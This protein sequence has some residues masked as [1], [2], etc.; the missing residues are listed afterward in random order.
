[1]DEAQ[2]PA[3]WVAAGHGMPEVCSRHGAPASIRKRITI[4]S[5]AARRSNL[6]WFVSPV[7]FLTAARAGRKRVRARLWP[8]C[9]ACQGSRVRLLAI[10][11][12]CFTLCVLA[13]VGFV[14][15]IMSEDSSGAPAVPSL[16][17][18]FVLIGVG[19]LAIVAGVAVTARG[20]MAA[21]AGARV[22]PDG[23]WVLVRNAHVN[24]VQQV[25]TA[26]A[27][28]PPDR[29]PEWT[30]QRSTAFGYLDAD[31]DSTWDPHL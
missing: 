23:G 13:F 5:M 26:A 19:L 6:I 27:G 8:F 28:P 22:C 17:V 21:I 4:N 16:T 31:E 25:A 1:M 29:R 10:S 12:G 2:I 15:A 9:P 11:I 30:A 3:D 20:T 14:A 7:T 18:L 24:F